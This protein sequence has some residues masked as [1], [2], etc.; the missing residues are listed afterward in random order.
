MYRSG[1]F[2]PTKDEEAYEAIQ[3]ANRKTTIADFSLIES[4]NFSKGN[5]PNSGCITVDD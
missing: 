5:S 2:N 3:S 4:S 1:F